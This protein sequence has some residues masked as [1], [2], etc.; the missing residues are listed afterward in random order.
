MVLQLSWDT[1]CFIPMVYPWKA[2]SKNPDIL[3]IIFICLYILTCI[4]IQF[5]YQVLLHLMSN[6]CG[7]HL[8]HRFHEKPYPIPTETIPMAVWV[9]YTV[10]PCQTLWVIHNTQVTHTKPGSK[11]VDSGWPVPK[12]GEYGLGLR[13]HGYPTL[14][15]LNLQIWTC[16]NPCMACMWTPLLN[17]RTLCMHWQ[18]QWWLQIYINAPSHPTFEFFVY[19]HALAGGVSGQHHDHATFHNKDTLDKWADR[20]WHTDAALILSI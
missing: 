14:N 6:N 19:S 2:L 9:C 10:Y 17:L 11:P 12:W 15:N 4:W 13:M 16:L 7:Y 3:H 1:V 18:S 8:Y 5:K 20:I